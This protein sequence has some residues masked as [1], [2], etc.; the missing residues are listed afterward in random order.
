MLQR[1]SQGAS[2]CPYHAHRTQICAQGPEPSDQRRC[3]ALSAAAAGR[4]G[5]RVAIMLFS[6]SA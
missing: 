4:A 3:W 2:H 6:F 1:R 5:R